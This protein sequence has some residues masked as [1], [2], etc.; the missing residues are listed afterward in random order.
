M[1]ALDRRGV[2]HLSEREAYLEAR[3][4]AL[5]SHIKKQ[6]ATIEYLERK[7]E[8]CREERMRSL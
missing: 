3:I 5:Q 7:L 4:E 1:N 2:E 8:Q 6:D